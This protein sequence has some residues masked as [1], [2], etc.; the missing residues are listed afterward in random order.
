MKYFCSTGAVATGASLVKVH[1]GLSR[2][3]YKNFVARG[4]VIL[5]RHLVWPSILC[6]GQVENAGPGSVV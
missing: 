4:I 6:F 2:R 1:Y 5:G 3:V